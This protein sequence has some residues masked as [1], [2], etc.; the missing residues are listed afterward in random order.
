MLY[1]ESF[2]YL[3]STGAGLTLERFENSRIVQ[4]IFATHL[5]WNRNNN[6]WRLENYQQRIF[7]SDGEI[8]NKGAGKD[9]MLPIKPSEF[10]IKSQF[11]SAMTNPELNDYIRKQKENGS[12]KVSAYYVELY[13]RIASAFSF[14]PL[15]LLAVAISSRKVRGG[16]GVHLGLG[17]MI[18]LGY[19]LMVQVFYTFGIS[20]VMNPMIAVWLPVILISITAALIARTSPK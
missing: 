16:I 18:T 13:K 10:I 14:L 20:N 12:S 19:L 5:I 9:T 11:I 4:R 2:N 7:T 17:I 6:M 8:L 15:T 3:D 1:I